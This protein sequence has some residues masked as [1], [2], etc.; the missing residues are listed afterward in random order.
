MPDTINNRRVGLGD[1]LVWVFRAARRADKRR[2]ARKRRAAAAKRRVTVG[3]QQ[4]MAAAQRKIERN[5]RMRQAEMEK[6]VRTRLR[7]QKILDRRAGLAVDPKNYMRTSAEISSEA[8]ALIKK[9]QKY[10][11]ERGDERVRREG[12]SAAEWLA[13]RLKD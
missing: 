1:L 7:D 6:L 10:L 9:A 3:T 4:M 13:R 8:T 2:A 11:E 5:D 12:E